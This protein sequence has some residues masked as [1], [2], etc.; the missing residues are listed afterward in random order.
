MN[1]KLQKVF[2]VYFISLIGPFAI[3]FFTNH[4]IRATRRK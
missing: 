4:L 1:D 3:L 2:I